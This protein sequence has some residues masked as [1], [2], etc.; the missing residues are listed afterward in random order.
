M[1]KCDLCGGETDPRDD[2]RFAHRSC[3]AQLES[4]RGSAQIEWEEFCAER[5]QN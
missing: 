3:W 1:S 4:D 2:L 5:D